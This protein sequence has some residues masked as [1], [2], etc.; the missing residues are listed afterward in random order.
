M[1]SFDILSEFLDDKPYMTLLLTVDGKAFVS[2]LSDIF[3]KL[4]VLNK[5]LQ[6][7]NMTLV[8]S[9]AKIFGF[10]SFMEL[11]QENISV[12]KMNNFVG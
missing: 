7:T 8:N 9:N 4:D 6:G 3:E 12:K 10:I 11:C 1:E 2:Y 5:K